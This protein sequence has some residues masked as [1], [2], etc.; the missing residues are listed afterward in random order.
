MRKVAHPRGFEPL[1][2]AFGGQRSIQ[3]SYGCVGADLAMATR[4]G[5]RITDD[6]P[7]P[8]LHVTASGDRITPAATAPAGAGDVVPLNS[9][10]VG[11]IVGSARADLHRAL[12]PFLDPLA[13][14]G[15]HR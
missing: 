8:V 14:S 2:S 9:G 1:A 12:G 6:L 10:H 3:L 4:S 13:G 11:M 15:R 5:K 7:V